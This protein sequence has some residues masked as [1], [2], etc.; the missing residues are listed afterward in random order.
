[1]VQQT[2]VITKRK[3]F[4]GVDIPIVK[5]KIE[6]VG[7][8]IDQ[9]NGRTVKLDLTRQLRGKS[10]EAVLKVK[11]EKDSAI[12]EPI[13]I[14]LMP[15]FIRR[16]I[17]KR[18]SYV[19]DSFSV[20]TQESLVK[21][22]PFL[23]T[24]KKVS[25]AVRRTLRNLTK[26]WLE[27]YLAER[28]DQEI[29]N[30]I[31]TNRLQ[32]PLSLKLKKT[33]PLSLCEIRVLEIIRPLQPSEVPKIEKKVKLEIEKGLDQL[34]EIEREKIKQAQEEIEKTQKM[35]IKV[36]E[37]KESPKEIIKEAEEKPKEEIK[38]NKTKDK[39][40]IEAKKNLGSLGKEKKPRKT[41]KTKDKEE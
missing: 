36:E 18:I 30:D 13:K 11:I 28:K 10:V 1:M 23:I 35:A 9:L 37:T 34:A 24:R 31:L 26:N 27:D 3:K 32:K 33:Y 20:P 7:E 17:R 4:F 16:M 38:E 41:K 25:R 12:A 40:E 14:V 21:V 19:E 22:K 39:K 6:L 15:Y 5:T 8:T 29:F 2:K